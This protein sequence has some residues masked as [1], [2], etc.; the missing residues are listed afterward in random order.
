[1]FLQLSKRALSVQPSATLTVAARA[2]ALRQAGR[3]VI[4]LAAGEPDFDTPDPI[5]RAAIRAIEEGFTKYTAVE[6]TPGLKRAVVE[7]FRR[8][9][10][11]EYA[12]EQVLVSCG[13]KHSF[14]NLVMALLGPGDEV[15]VPAPYWTSYP[16]MVRLAEGEPVVIETAAADR[17]K[18]TAEQLRAAI[19]HKTKLL[20]LNSPANPTGQCYGRKELEALAAV[21]LEHPQVVVASDDIYEHIL[22]SGE[23]FANIVNVCPALY[24]RTVVLNGVSKTYAMTGWRIGYAAGPRPLIE[25]MGSLQSQSTSNPTSIAQVAAQAALEGEQGSVREHCALFR[26]RH[27]LVYAR[28]NALRGIE[29]LPAQG[30][31]Y[32]FPQVQGAIDSLGL[33]D[34]VDLAER[35]LVEAEVATV[36]GAAFGAPGHLRL[37]FA[38]STENLVTALGRM[39][40]YLGSK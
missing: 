24:G 34:D 1:M 36:P 20:I 40:A 10:G 23:P 30:T 35:L 11:L 38:T 3:P 4:S 8:E 12:P 18:L 33:A 22:W 21:L 17:Y 31:F 39:E 5:K 29:C 16:D 27:A 6:G 9:N 25:A 26:E 2:A 37:S 19:T 32:S 28:L 15:L 13:C 7:K 14:Y